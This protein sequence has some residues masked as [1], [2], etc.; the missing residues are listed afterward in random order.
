MDIVCIGK[1]RQGTTRH[2][3]HLPLETGQVT[4]A[5]ERPPSSPIWRDGR[6]R[7]RTSW[8]AHPCLAGVSLPQDYPWTAPTPG[9]QRETNRQNRFIGELAKLAR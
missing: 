8:A 4:G 1:A 9:R 6:T 3:T 7:S 2:G 5:R